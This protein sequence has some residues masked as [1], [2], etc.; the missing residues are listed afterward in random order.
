L[1]GPIPGRWAD[2]KQPM[3][4]DIFT[5][6]RDLLPINFAPS[7]LPQVL[8][9]AMKYPEEDTIYACNNDSYHY[10][11]WKNPAFVL[12]SEI[13]LIHVLLK[14]DNVDDAEWCLLLDNE[15]KSQS[16]SLIDCPELLAM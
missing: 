8:T 10:K 15:G 2:S 4:R 16:I 1:I 5:S 3:N 6:N 11:G 12:D 7:G 13:I 14:G 9:V